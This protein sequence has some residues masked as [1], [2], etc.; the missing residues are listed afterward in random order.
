MATFSRSLQTPALLITNDRGLEYE[1][2]IQALPLGIIVLMV[3]SNTIESIRPLL[4]ELHEAIAN[5]KAGQLIK[6]T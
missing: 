2:N 6:L 4:S 3:K 5:L 1:Q